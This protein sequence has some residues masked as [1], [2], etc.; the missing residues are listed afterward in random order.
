[1]RQVDYQQF[2]CGAEFEA[3]KKRAKSA[4]A[5]LATGKPGSFNSQIWKDLKAILIQGNNGKCMYFEGRYVAGAHD[6]AEHYRPKGDVTAWDTASKQRSPVTHPGYYWLAYEWQNLLLACAKCNSPH[7]DGEG[8]RAHQGKLNEFP[9]A[10]GT[11]RHAKPGPDPEKWW[12]ELKAEHPLL[13]HPY[14]DPCEDHFEARPNGVVRGKT[15][16]G[17]ATIRTCDLNRP[18]LRKDRFSAEEKIRRDASE[19]CNL[20]LN[21]LPFA[22]HLPLPKAPFSLYLLQRLIHYAETFIRESTGRRVQ[23]KPAEAAGS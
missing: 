13:L 11:P 7:P 10:T 17:R 3:W 1:M 8:D 12:D 23:L 4:R 9:L 6:D 5:K 16:Q 20:Y 14:F 15:P 18:E 21:G 2:L 19:I 22:N